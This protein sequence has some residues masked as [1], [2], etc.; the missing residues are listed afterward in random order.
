MLFKSKYLVIELE[1][2]PQPVVFSELTTHSDVAQALRGTV[3]SAGFCY[4]AEGL[5]VCY[6][7][8]VS[9]RVKSRGD[10][11][12]KILNRLLGTVEA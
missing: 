1:G 9:C 8:S 10:E 2:I 3:L 4:I 11:D 5:Y 6:G 7:E 12:S